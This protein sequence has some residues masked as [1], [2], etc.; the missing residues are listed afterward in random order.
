MAV[1]DL[2]VFSDVLWEG[3]VCAH[4]R[5]G[6]SVKVEAISWFFSFYRLP[7]LEQATFQ[8]PWGRVIVPWSL[9]VNVLGHTQVSHFPVLC[10]KTCV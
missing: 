7:A 3:A 8:V 5:P 1:V 6:L 4:Q 10:I 9:F 2:I